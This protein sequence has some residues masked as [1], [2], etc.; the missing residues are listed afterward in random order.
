VLGEGQLDED[1]MD[2][3]VVI[4]RAERV[5]QLGLR[6]VLVEL[7]ELGVDVCLPRALVAG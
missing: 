5:Q 3:G 6:D 2:A 1:A 4:V 7:D